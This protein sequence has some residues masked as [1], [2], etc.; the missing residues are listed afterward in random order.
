MRSFTTIQAFQPRLSISEA[1]TDPIII[2]T[3]DN[4]DTV[5]PSRPIISSESPGTT[6]LNL[7]LSIPL[8]SS[9]I[10]PLRDL[11]A[12]LSWDCHIHNPL[13]KLANPE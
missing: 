12:T 1:K 8:P 6:T 5:H 4:N 13:P 7:P 10:D 2:R 3:F 9:E 11:R